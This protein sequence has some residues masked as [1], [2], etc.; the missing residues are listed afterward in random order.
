MIPLFSRYTL[1]RAQ[2]EERLGRALRGDP[3]RGE[4]AALQA[5][6]NLDFT[7]CRDLLDGPG[8]GADFKALLATR[9]EQAVQRD[10]KHFIVSTLVNGNAYDHYAR[11]ARLQG[12]AVSATVGAAVERDFAASRTLQQLDTEPL[13]P[14]LI[15]Y[16]RELVELLRHGDEDPDLAARLGRLAELHQRLENS[17]ASFG[18][19]SGGTS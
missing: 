8:I 9:L 13:L 19:P 17:Q 7:R 5:L 15:G 18:A 6:A 11:L 1:T 2:A 12:V 4:K 3:L 16:L 10:G 14:A